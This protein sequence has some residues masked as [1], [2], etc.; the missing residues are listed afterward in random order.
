LANIAHQ[1]PS[2]RSTQVIEPV[3]R[4]RE[5]LRRCARVIGSN[6]S[7]VLTCGTPGKLELAQTRSLAIT[8]HEL[9]CGKRAFSPTHSA[10]FSPVF[11][12]KRTSLKLLTE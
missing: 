6:I 4:P 8:A 1:K 9:M 3:P 2:W 11:L 10:R 5:M 12:S 7:T